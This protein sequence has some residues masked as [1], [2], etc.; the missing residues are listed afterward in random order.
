MSVL[1]PITALVSAVVPMTWGLVLGERLGP[2]GSIGLVLALAAVVLVAFVPERTAVR[3][4]PRGILMAVGAGTLIGVFLVLI[5]AAPDDSGLLPLLAN[6]TVNAALMFAAV[7]ILALRGAPRTR[8]AAGRGLRLALL[9]GAL[10]GTANALLLAGVRTGDLTVVSVLTALYPAGTIVL[11]ALVLRE[12]I[13]KLQA[14][15]LVLAF[16]AAALLAVD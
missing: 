4:S 6:R 10:D 15:G 11:A 12:R 1:S 3:A 16:V 13:T 5:D 7:G 2:L 8:D 9:C 14:F